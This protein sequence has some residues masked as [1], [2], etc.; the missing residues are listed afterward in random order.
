MNKKYK[1]FDYC[2]H[3]PHQWDMIRALR[4]DCEFY[5][6]LAVFREWDTT[7]RDLPPEINFVTH[8]EPGIYDVALL[9]IDQGIIVPNTQKKM[10]YEH[11]NSVI[12]DIP[13]IVLNHGSPVI[14]EFF[15]EIGLS[16]SDEEAEKQCVD[17][18]RKIIGKNVMVVNSH[19]AATEREWGWGVPIVHGIDAGEWYDL[20][21]EPRVFS[22]MS[23]MGFDKYY[24]RECLGEVSDVLYDEYGYMLQYAR[25]NTEIADSPEA[26]KKYLGKSLLYLDTSF[27]TP[28]NR[29]RTE[30]FLSGCCVIQ[31]E[32]AHDLERWAKAGENILLVPND[33]E[34]IA[35]VIAELL[36]DGYQKAI[37]IG[38][39]GKEMAIKEFNPERY[40]KDWLEL[41]QNLTK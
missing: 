1:I 27:R 16:F 12:T 2:W 13:K 19:T 36:H 35:K 9:H 14:P 26:Y 23:A 30:A 34:K 20:P 8:Y 37:Q 3:I 38:Q 40:R 21:K 25:V 17:A 7:K 15:S 31:V 22:A 5:Y 41:L 18:V 10:I 29:A 24:N 11:F 28:M 32:G 39:K 4:N 6:C 33:P